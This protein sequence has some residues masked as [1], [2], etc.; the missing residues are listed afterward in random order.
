[1]TKF[2]DADGVLAWKQ[3]AEKA[4]S[5][6]VAW[7]ADALLEFEEASKVVG[8]KRIGFNA[9]ILARDAVISENIVSHTNDDRGEIDWGYFVPILILSK[10]GDAQLN[11]VWGGGNGGKWITVSSG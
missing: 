1:M 5:E 3:A 9:K 10:H 8:T 6:A 2:L 11:K 7:A 4:N